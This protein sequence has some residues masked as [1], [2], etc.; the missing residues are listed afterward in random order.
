MDI[1][2]YVWNCRYG[3]NCIVRVAPDGEIDRVIELPV[4]RPTNCTFGGPN[5][6]VLYITSATP[7]AGNWERFGGGLFALETNVTGMA[8]SKFQLL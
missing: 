7:G 4:S 6:N 2:G 1:E 5:G 8:E 3:G